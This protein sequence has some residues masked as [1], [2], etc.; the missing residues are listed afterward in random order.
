V[1]IGWTS[2]TPNL[3][4]NYNYPVT[5]WRWGLLVHTHPLPGQIL[6]LV[7]APEIFQFLFSLVFLSQLYLCVLFPLN[8]RGMN[9]SCVVVRFDFKSEN[10]HAEILTKYSNYSFIGVA[11]LSNHSQFLGI[12]NCTSLV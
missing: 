8:Q 7:N 3:N 1:T 11:Q 5:F 10:S 4:D 2:F 12:D 9:I 6:T